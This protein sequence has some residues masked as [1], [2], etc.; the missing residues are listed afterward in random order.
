MSKRTLDQIT[1]AYFKQRSYKVKCKKV[2]L[3]LLYLVTSA[4]SL[5]SSSG[6]AHAQLFLN[7]A[8]MIL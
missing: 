1:V 8:G 4:G 3:M 2:L 5:I 7:Q 6:V